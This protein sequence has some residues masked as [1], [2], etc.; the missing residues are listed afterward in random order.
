MTLETEGKIN[1]LVIFIQRFITQS[2]LSLIFTKTLYF[3][4]KQYIFRITHMKNADDSKLHIIKSNLW[5]LSFWKE[6]IIAGDEIKVNVILANKY[7]VKANN[8]IISIFYFPVSFL[9]YIVCCN[10]STFSFFT[11]ISF[12]FEDFFKASKEQVTINE[13]YIKIYILISRRYSAA[14]NSKRQVEVRC[15]SIFPQ[16]EPSQLH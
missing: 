15:N 3:S 2:K 4:I 11:L 10:T 16:T 12:L 8:F 7:K 1:L 6:P 9:Q 14:S 13:W 5:K